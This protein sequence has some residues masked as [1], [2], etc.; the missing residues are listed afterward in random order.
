MDKLRTEL[1]RRDELLEEIKWKLD[2]ALAPKR[3]RK[4]KKT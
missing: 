1:W 3:S 2:Q 4:K